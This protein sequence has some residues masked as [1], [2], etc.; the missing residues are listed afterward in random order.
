MTAAID[1]PHVGQ[2]SR[3]WMP[4]GGNSTRIWPPLYLQGK[5]CVYRHPCRKGG[6]E[7]FLLQHCNYSSR[8]FHLPVTF[9]TSLMSYL[10]IYRVK[11]HMDLPKCLKK[12]MQCI[13]FT[14]G[15][16]FLLRETAGSYYIWGLQ[17][18]RVKLSNTQVNYKFMVLP[19][20]CCFQSDNYLKNSLYG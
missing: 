20:V 5:M 7:C 18:I 1:G 11:G 6:I 15:I 2:K 16:I 12:Y 9:S 13:K 17:Q 10:M 14:L 8:P 19:C 3:T 4:F